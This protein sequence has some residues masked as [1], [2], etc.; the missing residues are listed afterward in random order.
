MDME[1]YLAAVDSYFPRHKDRDQLHS[2]AVEFA[3]LRGSHS[4][5]TAKQFFNSF[6]D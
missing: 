2:A 4:G 5:R 3:R 6:S 1:Q